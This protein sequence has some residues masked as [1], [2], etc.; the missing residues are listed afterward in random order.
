MNW[1]TLDWPA[2]DRLRETFLK[3]DSSRMDYWTSR[4]DLASYDSTFGQRIAWKWDAVLKELRRRCWTPP[5]RAVLDWGCGSG[6]AGRRVVEWLGAERFDTL[7][8]FDRSALAMDFAVA[9]A[10]KEFPSLTIERADLNRLEGADSVGLLVLSHVLNELPPHQRETL[11]SL[12]TRADAVVWVEPGTYPDSR[13]LLAVRAALR[14]R[15]EL[16][17]PCTHQA[18][19][20][21]LTPE[22][23][24]HWCH[25][26][27]PPPPG[28]MGDS[29]WV[30]FA[31]RVGIDLRS[32]P[33]SFLVMEKNGLR[34]RLPSGQARPISVEGCS[35]IIGVPR[36]YKGYAKIFSCQREGVRDLMLQKRDVPEL[37]KQIKHSQQ[38]SVYRWQLAE[39]RIKNATL[40]TAD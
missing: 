25:F 16:V 33:F 22:N 40:P 10:R 11:L 7:R 18:R 9:A 12:A 38:Q 5:S 24:R 20:G 1:E 17:A 13:A 30:R 23:E 37:F 34:E 36:V 39:D 32:L 8:C 21:L 26:F 2:L 3:S 27:A 19:C 31:Q 28:I 29:Q 4:A 14:E 35:R 6:I 15:F